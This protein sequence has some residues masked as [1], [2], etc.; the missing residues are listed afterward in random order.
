MATYRAIK[1]PCN[2]RACSSWMVDPVAAIQGVSF[3][4]TQAR[5]V[6]ALLNNMNYEDTGPRAERLRGC[7]AIVEMIDLIGAGNAD[8]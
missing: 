4:E 6:A 7:A 3:T 1:C 2:H 8:E 5:A